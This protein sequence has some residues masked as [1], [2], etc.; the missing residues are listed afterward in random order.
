MNK[1]EL[2]SISK[3]IRKDII[4]MICDAKS[5]HP[6][7]SLSCADIITYLYYEKMNVNV[8]KPKDLYRDRF[9]LSKGHAAPALYAVLAEKGYFDKSELK[10]LRKIG[11]L[12]QG[13]PDCKHIPGV[14]VSTGSLGQG[15]SNA[16]GMAL[17]LKAQGN[18]A[19]VYVVLGDGEL[20]EG[21]VW[22]ASMAAAHYKLDNL[23]AIVDNNGLQID[24]KN[25]E[26]M[27]VSPIDEKFHSFGWNVINCDDGNDY[28]KLHEAFLKLG[29]SKG[30]PTVII[31]KT[32][33]GKCV[34]FMEN[35]ACW[36]GQAPN[37]EEKEKALMDISG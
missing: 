21:L 1:E 12:L 35:E 27:T 33:K 4:C 8:K 22:E 36:H 23:V 7:G 3:V 17:G 28:D 10:H 20:Q 19:K 14:D 24:G 5:G 9:V 18:K 30:K 37:E 32:I 16:V 13:H 11:A 15:I 31:A 25:E 2:I 29:E 6:G 26:V 34:S